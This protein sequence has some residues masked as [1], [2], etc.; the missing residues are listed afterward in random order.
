MKYFVIDHDVEEI[1]SYWGDHQETREYI[2]IF[3]ID[4][5]RVLTFD[6]S[7]YFDDEGMVEHL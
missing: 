6:G 3:V 7:I 2:N 5:N 1:D 4:N